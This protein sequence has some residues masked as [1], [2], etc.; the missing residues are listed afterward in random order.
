MAIAPGDGLRVLARILISQGSLSGIN[1]AISLAHQSLS[2]LERPE[3]ADQDTRQERADALLLLQRGEFASGNLEK[4]RQTC[5]RC[6][7]LYKVL[8]DR[9]GMAN[10]LGSLGAIAEYS[11]AYDEAK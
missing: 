10:A 1:S 3:L 5:G 8:D 9:W 2:L 4:A 11:G 7:S 6:L